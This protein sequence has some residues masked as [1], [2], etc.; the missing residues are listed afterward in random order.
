M[1]KAREIVKKRA[2][3]YN[4]ILIDNMDYFDSLYRPPAE[5]DEEEFSLLQS[6]E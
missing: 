4:A 2:E 3:E 1:Q 5:L 6:F